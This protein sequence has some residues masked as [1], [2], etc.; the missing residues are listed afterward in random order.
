MGKEKKMRD[1]EVQRLLEYRNHEEGKRLLKQVSLKILVKT[2]LI[3]LLQWKQRV[4][5]GGKANRDSVF[6]KLHQDA[7]VKAKQKTKVEIEKSQ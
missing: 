2:N 3:F 4:T 6:D 5:V 7:K 1:S